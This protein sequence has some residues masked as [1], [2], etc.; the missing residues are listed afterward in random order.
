MGKYPTAFIACLIGLPGLSISTALAN[1]ITREIESAVSSQNYATAI[2]LLDEHLL[3]NPHDNIGRFKRAQVLGWKGDYAAARSEYEYLVNES[4][5]N[6]DY[7][8]GY[9]QVLTWQGHDARALDELTHAR[10]LAPGYEAVWQLQFRLLSRQNDEASKKALS[11]FRREVRLQFP[12]AQWLTEAPEITVNSRWTVHVGLNVENLSDDLPGWN[13]QFLEMVSDRNN[14]SRYFVRAARDER[15]ENS[16]N[17]IGGGGD[18][19]LADNWFTG[20]N[21]HIAPDADFQPDSEYGAHAG[22]SLSGGWVLNL[23]YRRRNYDTAIVD[24]YI[25]TTE[26]YFGNFRAAY[27]LSLSHL[28]GATDS[29][30]HTLTINWYQTEHRSFGL[31]INSGEE[32]EAI[33]AGQVLITDVRGIN[34]TGRH[35]LSDRVG[36]NWWF[37]IHEQGDFYRRQYAGLAVS[38]RL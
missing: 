1:E 33:G 15:F 11:V 3:A 17:T 16:D 14:G 24:S 6:V 27:A 23:G 5:D 7:V 26:R 32:A 31:S 12:H 25:A 30:G 28:H 20:V 35:T 22:R 9:A 37:G 29:A 4:P 8:L 36:L 21:L 18:W 2:Y 38:F 19:E 13:Q 10:Q 34:L